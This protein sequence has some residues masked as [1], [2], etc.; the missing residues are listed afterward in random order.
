MTK[1]IESMSV[2]LWLAAASLGA[3][4]GPSR[5]CKLDD[6]KGCGDTLVCEKVEGKTQGMC[7]A[8]VRIEGKVFELGSGKAIAKAEVA[9]QDIN[10]TPVGDVAAS[11]DS[12]R[13]SLRVPSVRT[14]D[15]G[16]FVA[17]KVT[18][19][20]S[21]TGYVTFP[22]GIRVA[23]P[24]D[25]TGA[26]QKDASSPYLVTG[27]LADIGLSSLP[28]GEQNLPSITGTVE[29]SA[30]Q[31]GVLVVAEGSGKGRTAVADDKGSFRIF[32]VPPGSYELRA[33][34]RG[35]NYAK[36]TANV[37]A[38]KDTTGVALKKNADP[39]ATLSGSIS[40]VAGANGAGTSVV[41]VVES[42]FNEA[43]VR[44]E[45]PPGLRAPEPGTAPNLTGA[46]SIDGV[47]DG[48]YVVLAGFENDG[49]VRDPDPN[50]SGTQIVHLSV[51]G[52]QAS[53]Q[54]SFKVTGAVQMVG[55]GA[56]DTLEVASATPTLAWKPYSS[57]KS[58]ELLVLDS[59]GNQVWKQ[60]LINPVKTAAGNIEVLYAGPAL[61]A[62]RVYQWRTTAYGNAGNPISVT[63]ELRGVFAVP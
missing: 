40:L 48:K 27:S 34:S 10:G 55:P 20:A 15:K 16:S 49:N 6:P 18:L 12:G 54:P 29:L 58:Y 53:A 56:G 37:E 39:T 26:V 51:A 42:T 17:R 36:A 61:D 25:T 43:L 14:D 52:G 57:A 7:F 2:G 44:G 32:N 31:R 46:F 35:S 5:E 1:R 8:P 33:Y 13:F 30:G 4:C 3:A 28:A 38:G 11:D 62:G 60:T 47:P 19:R 59:Q 24:I 22:S 23:L 21:A 50:I 45:A 63:E 41:L 9:A